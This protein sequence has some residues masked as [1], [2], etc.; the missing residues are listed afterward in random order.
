MWEIQKRFIAL[1]SEQE[2]HKLPLSEETKKLIQMEEIEMVQL[3]DSNRDGFYQLV[4]DYLPDSD[5]E[6]VKKRAGEY[7]KA[8][9]VLMCGG[10]VIGVAFGWPR[11]LDAA[12]EEGFTLDGI[13]VEE[14]YQKRRY[15]ARLLSAFERAAAEYG[16]NYISVGSAGGYVEKFYMEN[17]YRPICFKSYSDEG[18]RVEKIFEN[19]KDYEQ[20]KRPTEEGFVV[21]GKELEKNF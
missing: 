1:D 21:M 9:P 8:Y 18:I 17:G 5:L 13:A 16:Y 14:A 7:P 2:I 4:S 10:T 19:Q 6:K 12:K 15:G 11:N 20:Y 3:D